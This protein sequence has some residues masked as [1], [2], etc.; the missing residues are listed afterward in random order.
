MD[1]T[2]QKKQMTNNNSSLSSINQKTCGFKQHK[3]RGNHQQSKVEIQ[4]S[5]RDDPT[6]E[7]EF[8]WMFI[9]C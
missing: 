4:P 6:M 8:I 7:L 3:S 5:N 1:I 9:G 2:D